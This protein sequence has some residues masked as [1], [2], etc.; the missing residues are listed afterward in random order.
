[1]GNIK[2]TEDI[3][4]VLVQKVYENIED[5]RTGE[6]KKLT[7]T[8]LED[9]NVTVHKHYN[10]KRKEVKGKILLFPQTRVASKKRK[11]RNVIEVLIEK[12]RLLFS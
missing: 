10:N 12:V 5:V 7:I 1:M 9:G 2:L 8:F 11:K 3:L 6:L 4:D